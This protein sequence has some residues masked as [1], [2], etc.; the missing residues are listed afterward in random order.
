MPSAMGCCAV[1]SIR[2]HRPSYA[3][4]G[5]WSPN[6]SQ[7]PLIGRQRRSGSADSSPFVARASSS[8]KPCS[9]LADK[10]RT[11][12]Q[13][14]L[15]DTTEG[16]SGRGPIGVHQQCGLGPS[17]P[18]SGASA[19]ASMVGPQPGDRNSACQDGC[20]LAYW[21]PKMGSRPVETS[22]STG[23]RLRLHGSADPA[24]NA[25]RRGRAWPPDPPP[26]QPLSLDAPASP[27]SRSGDCS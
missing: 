8:M 6:T 13:T 19:N 5:I 3:V 2:T 20:I 24:G 10:A 25:S 1:R 7:T 4:G 11:S 12:H 17:G 23:E 15:R 27:D 16:L 14:P 26:Y 22:G 18:C 9:S 21:P